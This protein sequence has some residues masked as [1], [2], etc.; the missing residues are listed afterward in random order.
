[1]RLFFLLL[2]L[3]VMNTRTTT[4]NPFLEY[5]LT[6]SYIDSGMEPCESVVERLGDASKRAQ[7]LRVIAPALS[8]IHS[9][10]KNTVDATRMLV[11]LERAISRC[12]SCPSAT[13]GM[14]LIDAARNTS[15][16]SWCGN[17]YSDKGKEKEEAVGTQASSSNSIKDHHNQH[18]PLPHFGGSQSNNNQ[19]N[20]SKTR[21]RENSGVRIIE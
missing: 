21:S 15:S 11:I 5:F 12:K 4:A 20:L 9:G 16:D 19:Q 2:T 14:A 8:V 13:F 7:F 6:M 3:L 17:Q 1:M 18:F 10:R